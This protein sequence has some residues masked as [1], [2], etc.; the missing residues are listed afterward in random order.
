[1]IWKNRLCLSDQLG[2]TRI[3]EK[4]LW[5]PHMFGK[6]WYWLMKAKVEQTILPFVAGEGMYGYKWHTTGIYIDNQL[7]K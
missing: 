5:L 1:M 4:F 7:I 2:E 3:V 6:Y